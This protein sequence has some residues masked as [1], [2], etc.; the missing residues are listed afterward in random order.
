MIKELVEKISFDT[1][2][3]HQEL[4][5]NNKSN[6]INEVIKKILDAESLS[7][8]ELNIFRNISI[9]NPDLSSEEKETLDFI[10]FLISVNEPLE[11][12]QINLLNKLLV[13]YKSEDT[14][15]IS[16]KYDR[17]KKLIESLQS[18]EL[19]A[20]YDYL[21]DTLKKYNYSNKE[22]LTILKGIILSNYNDFDKSKISMEEVVEAEKVNNQSDIINTLDINKLKN[23]LK[24]YGFRSNDLS[25]TDFLKLPVEEKMFED[26]E[27]ILDFFTKLGIKPKNLY[28]NAPLDFLYTLAFGTK[29][30][31][32]EIERICTEKKINLK[33][34]IKNGCIVLNNDRSVITD[35]NI[36]YFGLYDNFIKNIEFFDSLNFN[37]SKAK[38]IELYYMSNN[39]CINCYKLYSEEYRCKLKSPQDIER[40]FTNCLGNCMDRI[41][42]LENGR[43]R[44][45]DGVNCI[46]ATSIKTFYNLKYSNE[47]NK[48]ASN[49]NI[50]DIRS[51]NFFNSSSVI[52]LSEI[53]IPKLEVTEYE[54]ELYK[55]FEILTDLDDIPFY[56][57]PLEVLV[58]HS[59]EENEYIKYLDSKYKRGRF[60]YVINDE[61]RV[62]RVKVLRILTLLNSK[63]IEINSD[64]LKFAMKFD[65]VG[66]EKDIENINNSL[67]DFENER[68][69]KLC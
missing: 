52:D 65:L 28:K 33:D 66:Y 4:E 35:N 39:L 34:L 37:H 46:G 10:E 69:K 26:M 5:K 29:E 45:L 40:I 30:H 1:E 13:K 64:A 23:I 31:A 14:S 60:V 54:Q 68:T 59:L 55:Y 19:F 62:S 6:R 58:D 48:N 20:D 63:G 42:E 32:D 15:I 17:N 41:L 25:E 47:T 38:Y 51:I 49:K 8:D 36:E 12:F 11:E 50:E 16:T 27:Y 53:V 67:N 21:L 9:T 56:A 61:T 2:E 43:E 3:M 7:D 18:K 24:K 22:I 44:L 57:I